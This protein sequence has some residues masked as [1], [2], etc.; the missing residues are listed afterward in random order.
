MGVNTKPKGGGRTRSEG[1]RVADRR[2]TDLALFDAHHTDDHAVAA[3]E[4]RCGVRAL[5]RMLVVAAA[6]GALISALAGS[7]LATSSAVLPPAAKPLGWSLERM[8]GALAV[9]TASGNNPAFYPD[10]PFQVLYVRDGAFQVQPLPPDGLRFTGSSTFTVRPGTK[11]FV[12]MANANDSPPFPVPFPD[13]HEEAIPYFFGDAQY[14]ARG[15]QISVDGKRK[16]IGSGYLAGPVTTP[17]LPDGGGTH[18]I[19]LGAFLHPLRPG[20]HTVTVNGGFFGD[21]LRDT[22]GFGFF[23]YEFTYTV[24][25][26]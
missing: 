12:P 13:T 16:P 9:F 5:K 6:A 26:A 19:T 15:W 4:G 7:A 25:V 1:G 23:V 20:T 8:T 17:P 22:Y 18:M 21:A 11:F 10:T 3:R 24:I 2:I 14:G